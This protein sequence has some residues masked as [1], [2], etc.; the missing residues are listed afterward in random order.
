MLEFSWAVDDALLAITHVLRCKDLE[1]EDLMEAR[2]SENRR[3]ID[4]N[5]NR[6]FFVPDPV[7]VEIV[8]LPPIEH[9]KAPLHPDFPGR[10]VREIPAGP[11]VQVARDDFE[12]LRGREV[13]LK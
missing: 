9:V 1:L 2:Y 3:L 10:G 13:R 11:K 12:K 4:K 6:Y 8:G 7:A 5:A